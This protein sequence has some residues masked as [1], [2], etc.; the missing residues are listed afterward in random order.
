MHTAQWQRHWLNFF[1]ISAWTDLIAQ[2]LTC[3]MARRD[4]YHQRELEERMKEQK[5][6]EVE[7]AELEPCPRFCSNFGLWLFEF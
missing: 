3:I 7:E 1:V 5:E 2:S 4:L 6:L